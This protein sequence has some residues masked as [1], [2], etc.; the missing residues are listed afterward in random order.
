MAENGGAGPEFAILIDFE[1]T[2]DSSDDE[3]TR[4]QQ[5]DTHEIIEFVRKAH[6]FGGSARTVPVCSGVARVVVRRGCEPA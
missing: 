5:C 3:L 4:L 1:A 2:S 6:F